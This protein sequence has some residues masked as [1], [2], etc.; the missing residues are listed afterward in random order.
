MQHKLTLGGRNAPPAE[1]GLVLAKVALR[2]RRCL[3]ATYNGASVLVAPYLLYERHQVPHLAAVTILREDRQLAAEKLSVYRLTG[4]SNVSL[5]DRPFVPSAELLDT[6]L[7]PVDR[8]L[9][10]VFQMPT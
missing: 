1:S 7:H 2:R 8:E 6:H 10:S 3:V 4:L 5:S 9:A